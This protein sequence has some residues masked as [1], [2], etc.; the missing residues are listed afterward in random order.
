[1]LVTIANDTNEANNITILMEQ[2][3]Q[4]INTISEVL[5]IRSNLHSHLKI[6]TLSS[7]GIKLHFDE[8][9]LNN[10]QTRKYKPEA[11]KI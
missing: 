1:M 2:M 10:K 11:S 9:N 8:G 7:A 5:G 4:I 6:T 3:L